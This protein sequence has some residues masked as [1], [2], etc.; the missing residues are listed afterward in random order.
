MA[1]KKSPMDFSFKDAIM[2]LKKE[3]KIDTMLE[4]IKDLEY[5]I[6]ILDT[7]SYSFEKTT[8]HYDKKILALEKALKEKKA[9][10]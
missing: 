7:K 10:K 9:K 5:K 2:G 8:R 3:L 1:F 4:T 6:K